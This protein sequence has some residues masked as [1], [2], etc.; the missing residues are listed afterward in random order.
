MTYKVL[1][2]LIR[3]CES[4]QEQEAQ[5]GNSDPAH[6]PGEYK[7][8]LDVLENENLHSLALLL[9]HYHFTGA[10]VYIRGLFA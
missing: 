7:D 1:L 4:L 2:T 9:E 3:R 6:Q 5:K 8:V 10:R